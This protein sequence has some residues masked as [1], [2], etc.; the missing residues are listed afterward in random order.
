MT[1]KTRAISSIAI[2]KE[3]YPD[4]GPELDFS[5]DFQLLIAVIL[6]AQ[7]TDKRVNIVTKE[8]FEKGGTAQSLAAMELEE[9][10]EIIKTIGFFRVKAKNIK[11]TARIIQSEYAGNVP[12]THKELVALPGVGNKTANVVL[13]VA[14]NVPAIAVDTHVFRLAHRLGFSKANNPDD[15]EKD[16]KKVFPRKD[17]SLAHHLLILHGRRVCKA[18]RPNCKECKLAEICPKIDVKE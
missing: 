11:E 10:E 13:S 16:L 4:A 6:S 12:R 9:I 8:L 1:K 5:T 2:L 17:W 15:T 3:T 14:M 7:T 18:Q